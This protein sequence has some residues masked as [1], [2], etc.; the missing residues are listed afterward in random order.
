MP[1]IYITEQDLTSP[2]SLNVTT[3]TVY[4]PGFATEIPENF[5]FKPILY[6]SLTDFQNDFG[7]EVPELQGESIV[8][9]YTFGGQTVNVYPKDSGYIYAVELLR[10]GVPVL[11]DLMLNKTDLEYF[12][13]KKADGEYVKQSKPATLTEASETDKNTYETEVIFNSTLGSN[14]TVL[15]YYKK[16]KITKGKNEL[17]KNKAHTFLFGNQGRFTTEELN[18]KGTYNIKFITSGGYMDLDSKFT[19][20]LNNISASRM[21]CVALI[22]HEDT[23]KSNG[24]MNTINSSLSLLKDGKYAAMF[25]PYAY[26]SPACLSDNINSQNINESLIKLPASF[27]YL[28][29]MAQAT[30][31]AP[32]WMAMAGATRGT[33]PYIVRLAEELNEAMAD[34]YCSRDGISINPIVNINPFGL[35]IWGNRT[36]FNNAT[37]GNLT[38]SSFLNIRNLISDVKKTVWTAARQMTFEQ[39]NDILWINFKALITPTLD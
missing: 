29:A 15:K 38:A 14:I 33:I 10:L 32:N 9:S 23:I 12:I 31:T 28:M 20:K 5:N 4:V 6:E 24:L 39:N 37:K 25:T 16:P 7:Y 18:Q 13:R 26:Y 27:G 3:N 2:G 34:S 35:I 19:S 1:N 36:L 21:D 11:Y 8:D 22:D 30:K 17:S